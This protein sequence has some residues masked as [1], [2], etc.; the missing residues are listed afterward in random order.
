M[1]MLG[2]IIFSRAIP[3]VALRI[4]D[5]FDPRDLGPIVLTMHS[6]HPVFYPKI[7]HLSLGRPKLYPIFGGLVLSNVKSSAEGKHGELFLTPWIKK[8]II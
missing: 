5:A 7:G 6:G 4:S 3:M 8:H 1:V 2:F